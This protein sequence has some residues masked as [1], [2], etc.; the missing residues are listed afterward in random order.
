L[1][2]AS[3]VRL[4]KYMEIM[5]HD[6]ENLKNALSNFGQEMEIIFQYV[7]DDLFI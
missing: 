2:L 7:S 1:T 3:N 6:T 5:Q 4:W